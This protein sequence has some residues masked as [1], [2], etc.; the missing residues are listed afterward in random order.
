MV[1]KYKKIN[2]EF[3]KELAIS[4]PNIEPLEKYHGVDG[5]IKCRCKICN[6]TFI[7][8]PYVLLQ[9]KGASGCRNC[10]GTRKRTHEEYCSLLIENNITVIPLEHYNNSYTKILHKCKKCN[11]SWKAKPSNILSGCLCPVCA[12]KVVVKGINDLW[13][14]HAHIAE[15]LDNP[16]D[17]YSITYGSGKKLLFRC[18]NCGETKLCVVNSVIKN[19]FSCKK[20]SD[21]ISFPMKFTMEVLNQLSINYNT[22]V[23]FDWCTFYNPY[24]KINTFG[25]Y[26]IVFEFNSQKYIIE[27]D[28]YFHHKDNSMNGQS[29]SE[30]SFIDSKK[31]ELAINN[32]YSIIRIDALESNLEYMR[33]SILS[34][35]SNNIFDLSCIDWLQCARVSLSSLVIKSA[36]LWNIYHR[37]SDVA[38]LLGKRQEVI[39]R[40]LHKASNLGLC[41]YD[42]KLEQRKSAIR[43]VANRKYYRNV[44]DLEEKN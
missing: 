15:I 11:Y 40:Y 41:N 42:G 44:K 14:T 22:E 34:S 4:K 3:L 5:K 12:N 24:K 28:G 2:D 10:N 17:G 29:K 43:T 20:C 35:E 19:G 13:T 36:E 21:G 18:P 25:I 37:A 16:S 33:Q 7:S 38:T 32:D 6:Y 30:A 9:N 23:R 27:V 8:T 31:D 1:E 26:D 39:V